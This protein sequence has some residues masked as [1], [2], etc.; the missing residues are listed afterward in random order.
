M[1]KVKNHPTINLLSLK[2]LKKNRGRNIIAVLAIALTTIMFTSVFTAAILVINANMNMEMR[3]AM[4]TSQVSI[5]ELTKEQFDQIRQDK[6]INSY[7]YSIFMTLLENRELDNSSV[8]MRYADSTEAKSYMCYPTSGKMP[9]KENEIAL[10]TITLDLLG[11]P[12]QV[13]STVPIICTLNGKRIE[14]DFVLSGY[15][16]G[17][18]L[19]VSQL[20]WVSKEFCQKNSKAATPEAIGAGDYEGDYNMSIWFGSLWQ[21]QK[22]T[23]ALDKAYKISDSQAKISIAPAYDKLIGE[24]GFSFGTIFF[25]LTVI[26]GAGY[27][28]IFNVFYISVRHDIKEYG[29]LKSIGTT[30]RQLKAIVSRQAYA[31]CVIGIPMGMFLGYFAGTC[32]TPYLVEENVEIAGNLMIQAGVKPAIFL[33]A[34]IFSFGTVY[35][36]CM[37]PCKAAA[38][39]SPIEAVRM[40]E[41][42]GN[43]K[44]KHIGNVTP[45]LMAAGNLKRTWKKAVVVILSLTLP[46]IILNTIFII[47][48]GF[49]TEKFVE[50]YISSDFHISGCTNLRTTSNLRAVTPKIQ[51]DLAGQEW[52][53]SV[54]LVYNLGTEHELNDKEFET[55]SE[56]ISNFKKTEGVKERDIEREEKYLQNSSVF[57][58]ILGV[59]ETAFQKFEF[60][61]EAVD[62]ET[63]TAGNYV[64]SGPNTDWGTYHKTGDKVELEIGSAKKMY[65]VIAVGNLPYDM[66]Y[67]FGSGTYF[68][69]TFYLPQEEYIAAA[70]DENARSV[71]IEI[72]DGK[73]KAFQK[74]LDSYIEQN[75]YNLYVD[76]VLEITKQSEQFANK[77][78]LVLGALGVIIFI[79]GVLNFFNNSAVSILG[80]R[81]E[82]S[83]LEAVGMTKQQSRRMLCY[84]GIFYLLAAVLLADTIGILAAK[85]VVMRTAGKAFY[86]TYRLN[87]TGSMMMLPVLAAIAIGV[88]LYNYKRMCRETIVER[89]RTEE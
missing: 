6:S 32:M 78:Y 25:L 53:E 11:I 10:S 35:A 41:V 2:F 74:W 72:K 81:K 40:Q 64:I 55:L 5:Q 86:F 26:F 70:G 16:K 88:P 24:D 69:Y 23:D 75:E 67:P 45:F 36:A 30:G 39:F 68:D 84:E 87:L 19:Y 29:L 48:S 71:H 82:L 17:D 14:K 85:E 57:T 9:K 49:D 43:K 65:T 3:M 66:E 52:V 27:L 13:G 58:N 73:E 60:I 28:I 20:G 46:I 22:K 1:T 4:T 59:N 61:E 62:W 80:R 51:K 77:Y 42:T 38:K 34:A 47:K 31:L 21:L 50:T 89:I 33:I 12:R 63:F 18:P 37:K 7:G 54:G 56:M 79:I 15:W 8:E 83:L 76:S 44:K